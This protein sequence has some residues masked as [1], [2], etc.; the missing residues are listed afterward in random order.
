[1]LQ[2]N[3]EDI[4]SCIFAIAGNVGRDTDASERVGLRRSVIRYTFFSK[5]FCQKISGCRT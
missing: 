3:S 4:P 2:T 1:M 5:G